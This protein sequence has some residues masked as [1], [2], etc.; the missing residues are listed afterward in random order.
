MRPPTKRVFELGR[1]D[2]CGTNRVF[3]AKEFQSRVWCQTCRI[4]ASQRA[5]F[6][7]SKARSDQNA[8]NLVGLGQRDVEF[9][10]IVRRQSTGVGPIAGFAGTSP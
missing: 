7:I 6:P 5:E 10:G 4:G 2:T 9:R 1:Y 3:E 8:R